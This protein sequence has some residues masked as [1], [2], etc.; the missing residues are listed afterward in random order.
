M[1]PPDAMGAASLLTIVAPETQADRRGVPR[2][3]NAIPNEMAAFAAFAEHQATSLSIASQLFASKLDIRAGQWSGTFNLVVGDS[4]ADRLLFWNARLFIPSWL[5]YDLCCLRITPE[6]V[7]DGEFLRTLVTLINRRNNVNA[8]SGGQPQVAIRSCSLNAERLEAIRQTISAARLWNLARAEA[9]AG[10]DAIVPTEEALS[11][12]REGSR[13]GNGLIPRTDWTELHGRDQ[14]PVRRCS[15][16][17]ISSTRRRAN[18]SLRA[19]G[20]RTSPRI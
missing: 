20:Q 14:Q 12:A 16:P 6:Q 3:L 11:K 10:P 9:V 1:F 13:F 2:D 17:I 8:G 7:E 19:T 5:D 18:S 4:F 15:R